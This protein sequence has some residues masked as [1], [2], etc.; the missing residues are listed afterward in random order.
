MSKENGSPDQKKWA[1]GGAAILYLL[2]AIHLGLF[3]FATDK[4]P[5]SSAPFLG[6]WILGCAVALLSLAMVELRRG[7]VFTGTIGMVFGGL[8]GLGSALSFI[9]S[10]WT[11]GILPIDGWW[12]LS[13]GIIL[14]LLL[15]AAWHISK[16]FF[17]GLT[18][19]GITLTIL[20]L[21]MIGVFG[22]P[23]TPLKIAGWGALIFAIFCWYNATAQ[24]V[25]DIYGRKILPL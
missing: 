25:N 9:R 24:M 5:S 10:L 3:A 21:G 18:E 13:A 16:L 22:A 23:S 1:S 12:F 4:V 15:P 11:P 2:G 8:L 14:F 7:E 17:G 19:I 20:G 6:F